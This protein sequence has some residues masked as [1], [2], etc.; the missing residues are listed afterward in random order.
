M[1]KYL[2]ILNYVLKFQYWALHSNV[3]VKTLLILVNY[4]L[5]ASHFQ[6][7]GMLFLNRHTTYTSY[8]I[9]VNQCLGCENHLTSYNITKEANPRHCSY[10]YTNYRKLHSAL[11]SAV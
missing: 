3:K 1:E 8:Y 7:M 9:A 6:S 10:S 2:R 4:C 11:I 5:V